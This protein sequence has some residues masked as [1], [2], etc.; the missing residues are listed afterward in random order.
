MFNEKYNFYRRSSDKNSESE[1]LLLWISKRYNLHTS[2]SVR[3]QKKEM[4]W[5]TCS[6]LSRPL[7]TCLVS[8]TVCKLLW[9]VVRVLM[10]FPYSSFKTLLLL[11]DSWSV[12][13]ELFFWV[14][15]SKYSFSFLFLSFPRWNNGFFQTFLVFNSTHSSL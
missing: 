6:S 10:D 7:T 5:M 9:E 15:L 14:P 4:T 13:H 2:V 3:L 12:L 11:W 1:S 8:F